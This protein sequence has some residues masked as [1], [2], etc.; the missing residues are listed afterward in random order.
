LT[1]K[2]LH[3]DEDFFPY[4]KEE[5]IKRLDEGDSEIDI[6]FKAVSPIKWLVNGP[7]MP[8]TKYGAL[9]KR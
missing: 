6:L 3:C 1:S 4:I 8:M 2:Q 5:L 7:S 9:I